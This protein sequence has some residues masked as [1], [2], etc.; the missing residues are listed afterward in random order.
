MTGDDRAHHHLGESFPEVPGL[1]PWCSAERC[2]V[3]EPTAV[4]V[5]VQEPVQWEAPQEARF[6]TG[7][8]HAVDETEPRVELSVDCLAIPHRGVDL[9]L[10]LPDA[11]RLR[12]QLTAHL[13]R[14]GDGPDVAAAVAALRASGVVQHG[15]CAE[16]LEAAVLAVLDAVRGVSADG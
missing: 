1:P 12:D 4:R 7:L 5:H 10:P 9:M 13:D 11:R 8:I 15:R 6:E 16:V 2:Y 14:A 3:C